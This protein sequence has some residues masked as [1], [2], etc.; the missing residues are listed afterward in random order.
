MG[1]PRSICLIDTSDDIDE[2]VEANASI[3][4]FG[5]LEGSL[6]LAVLVFGEDAPLFVE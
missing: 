4:L 2:I 3:S 1:M 6:Q 5:P